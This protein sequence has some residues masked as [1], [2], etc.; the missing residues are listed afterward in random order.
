MLSIQIISKLNWFNY[1]LSDIE[2]YANYFC[3][4]PH[5]RAEVSSV[6]EYIF[7]VIQNTW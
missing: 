1:K 3:N 6:N 5:L 7:V 2:L 4:G